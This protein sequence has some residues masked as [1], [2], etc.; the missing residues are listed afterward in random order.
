MNRKL[1]TLWLIALSSLFL[2]GFTDTIDTSLP[3]GTD[4]PSEADDNMRRIQGGFQEIINVEHDAALTVTA[5]TG[6]GTHTDVT[7]DSLNSDSIITPAGIDITHPDYGAVGDGATDDSAAI[8][9]AIDTGLPVIIPEGTFICEN[10]TPVDGMEIR[11]QGGTLKLKAGSSS[12]VGI[13]W[14][15]NAG[16]HYTNLRFINV[17]FD[18]NKANQTGT[19]TTGPNIINLGNVSDILIQ[20]CEFIGSRHQ[21][22][23]I[24]GTVGSGTSDF[25]SIGNRFDD[26][27]GSAHQIISCDGV[28]INDNKL[29]TIGTD[30]GN[31]DGFSG[32]GMLIVDCSGVVI[33]GNEMS[34]LSDSAIYGSRCTDGI[35]TGNVVRDA[36]KT[37]IKWQGTGGLTQNVLIAGNEVYTT[38]ANGIAIWS[39]TTGSLRGI[40]ANNVVDTT[41]TINTTFEQNEITTMCGI[42]C[43]NIDSIIVEGNVVRNAGDS[44]SGDTNDDAVVAG[45]FIETC[46][47]ASVLNNHVSESANNGIHIANTTHVTANNN[48]CWNNGLV[49][50]GTDNGI[51]VNANAVAIVYADVSHNQCFDLQAPKTQDYGIRIAGANWGDLKL[52]DNRAKIS[53]NL[54]GGF[55]MSA[56]NITV[57]SEG[58]RSFDDLIHTFTSTDATPSVA[59]GRD[60]ITAGT[61]AITDFAGGIEGQTI[62]VLA[63]ANI[64]I[65]DGADVIL[66]GGGNYAM[67]DSDT[68]T[69]KM[70][71]DTEWSEISRS[72]N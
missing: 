27:G 28:V 63:T 26:T 60:F 8:Q 61:T 72:V 52:H 34:V 14:S 46:T 47:I 70:F 50:A 19:R 54:T 62:Y 57:D 45:I 53:E 11:G 44:G 40:V 42:F 36:A 64:T 15:E 51:F 49:T 30:G 21:T 67:T 48:K 68:L 25:Q 18:G 66:A 20:G 55:L 23:R 16:T 31:K 3:A 43:Q 24:D 7:A 17:N 29:N 41:G 22:V 59:F 38:G 4:D 9:A 65:T 56:T 35:I 39:P 69:L 37:G 13:F 12:A 33:T 10:L 6:D 71:N 58:N 1:T 5:I 32:Q 2:V